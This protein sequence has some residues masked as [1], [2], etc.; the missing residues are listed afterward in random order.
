MIPFLTFKKNPLII[1]ARTRYNRKGSEHWN[2][3][4]NEY[5]RLSESSYIF[6]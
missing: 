1:A 2:I 6:Y 4:Y 5:F 3:F